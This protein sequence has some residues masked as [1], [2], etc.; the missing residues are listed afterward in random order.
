MR[1]SSTIRRTVA[2]AATAA[3]LITMFHAAPARADAG[4]LKLFAQ[5][6]DVTL[7]RRVGR[8][9]LLNVG[10]YAGAVGGA[11]EIHANRADYAS[12]VT[13]SQWAD[14]AWVQDLDASLVDGWD[15]LHGF[16]HLRV[17]NPAGDVIVDRDLDWCPNGFENQRIDDSGPDL[18][19]IPP[20]GC[21]VMPFTLGTVYGV[22][23]G[24]ATPV[25]SRYGG[26]EQVALEGRDGT[27]RVSYTFPQ[28]VIDT[29]GI[30]PNDA[31]A[32][33]TV[34]LVTSRHREAAARRPRSAEPS[35][36]PRVPNDPNP[37]PSTRPDLVALPA[38]SMRI[39]RP[40]S[41]GEFLTFAANI[42]NA[43][44]SPMVVEGFRRS[45]SD[46][47]DA[48]EYFYDGDTPVG[49]AEVGTFEFDTRDGHRHW[50]MDQFARYSLL[51]ADQTEVVRSTKQSFCL[52]PTD[53]IDLTVPGADWSTG[54]YG[55]GGLSSACGGASAL[56][57]REVLPAGWGDTYLQFVAGQSFGIRG[58]PNGRY[59]VE[60]T[61]NPTGEMIETSTDNNT[62]LRRVVLRGQPGHRRVVV[63]PYQLIDTDG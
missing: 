30:P 4:T 43:G 18:P 45:G 23:R 35:P 21:S 42:W 62:S 49:R 34:H 60:V 10:V 41:G 47:M 27:Y 50:H 61:A 52:F 56:W 36:A 13:G 37:D 14:G 63:P 11:F 6:P 31:R 9:P 32:D 40:R 1:G 25:A 7:H 2:V 15:G 28:A 38:W 29:F 8:P 39:Q 33:V 59:W 20:F 5:D 57:I 55:G 44:P 48:Y 19:R 58:L 53:I 26:A 22:D 17:E 3:T 54:W 51:N 12:P 46:V 16:L 24:W